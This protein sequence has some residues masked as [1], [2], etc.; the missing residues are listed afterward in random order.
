MANSFMDAI[1]HY[2]RQLGLPATVINWGAWAGEGMATQQTLAVRGLKTLEL[3]Q[4]L[5]WFSQLRS[6]SITQMGV[7]AMDWEGVAAQF[8]LLAQQP[9]WSMVLPSPTPIVLAA[10]EAKPIGGQALK[11]QLQRINPDTEG[12]LRAHQEALV[13]TYLQELLGQILGLNPQELDPTVSLLDLGLDSLMVM[14]AI[15]KLQS[16]LELMIYPREFYEHPHINSLAKYLVQ[17]LTGSNTGTEEAGIAPVVLPTI[18]T[19]YPAV[20]PEKRVKNVAL[21]LSSPRSGSTLL[22]VM[23]AGH[24]QLWVPPELHLLPFGYMGDRAQELAN[25]G[26]SQGLIKALTTL[27]PWSPEQAQA[28]VEDWIKANT[29]VGEV[30]QWLGDLTCDRLVIDKSPSYA[31]SMA[32]LQ[33]SEELFERPKYIHLVRHPYSVMD[34]FTRMRMDKLLGANTSNPYGLAESIWRESNQNILDLAAQID[35]D[36][37]HL[38]SYEELVTN[39]APVMEKLC[40]FL[41]IDYTPQLLQPYEGER[42]TSGLY[43]NSMAVGD[44]NFLQRNAIDPALAQV[45]KGIKLPHLLSP[46][47]QTLARQLA[48]SLPQE[49]QR[50]IP[51]PEMVETFINIRGLELCLCSWGLEQ[52]PLIFCVHGI[53]EQGAAWSQVAIELVNKRLSGGSSRSSGP[54][55]I[56]SCWQRRLL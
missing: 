1:G 52:S 37:Y 36:R 20:A 38:I 26:L 10:G 8:P 24:P 32:T 56:G 23:L 30:Y 7:M 28:Q 15:A 31:S 46:Q 12:T 54:W 3:S 42:M 43:E 11:A 22:R 4:G 41:A 21:L 5:Q 19:N 44:P 50:T 49:E 17:E 45:W 27:K 39:P 29:T 2:R 51:A 14:E 18:K 35:R 48:Y 33:R 9:Y 40:Q 34:S 55:A 16:E 53:L 25:S 13:K 47:T 6:S